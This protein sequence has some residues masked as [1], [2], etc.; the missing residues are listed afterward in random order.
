[1]K[2]LL[3]ILSINFIFKI[4]SI[5]DIRLEVFYGSYRINVYGEFDKLKTYFFI[6]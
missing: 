3:E 5:K 4:E 6:E 1:M 2:N